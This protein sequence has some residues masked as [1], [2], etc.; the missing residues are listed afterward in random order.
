MGNT[1]KSQLGAGVGSI[2]SSKP[3]LPGAGRKAPASS[4]R[5]REES[6]RAEVAEGRAPA[7][8]RGRPRKGTES[9]WDRSREF[10]TSVALNADQYKEIGDIAYSERKALKLVMFRLLQEGIKSYRKNPRVLG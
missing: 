10:H 5:E 7:V 6:I 8:T 4:Y 2:F 3:D 9:E 1:I